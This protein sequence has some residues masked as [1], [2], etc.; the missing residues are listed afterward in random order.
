MS[1]TVTSI[2]I[3]PERVASN[4]SIIR[5]V[6]PAGTM[7]V[8]LPIGFPSPL[9]QFFTDRVLTA[10]LVED[11]AVWLWIHPDESWSAQGPAVRE[12]LVEALAAPDHWVIEP[13]DDAVLR[14]VAQDVLAGPVGDVIR[15]HGGDAA[16]SS[17]NGNVVEV[18]FSGA[19]S[20]CPAISFTLHNRLEK[21]IRAR[22]PHLE[23][24][25]SA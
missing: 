3:Q 25:V 7:P 17:V 22:H 10:G 24:V 16:L 19:C 4:S 12:A 1:A 21:E 14:H 13:C 11:S 20:H 9:A 2:A 23:R 15:S 6:I 8:G 18:E 5:W